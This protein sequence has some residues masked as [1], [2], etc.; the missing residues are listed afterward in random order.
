MDTEILFDV[1][2][3]QGL[4]FHLKARADGRLYRVV[5]ARDPAQPR[6]WCVL[7]YRCRPGG[8]ADAGERPWFGAG[9]LSR[10]ELPEAF[11]A[12][13]TDVNAWLAQD[14]C[15]ALR[16]W[17]TAVDVPPPAVAVAVAAP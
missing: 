16:T 8:L 6:F 2:D 7:I 5:P 1:V 4:G 3:P 9:G 10:E 13:R 11:A 14:S 17:L 15:L 12:M